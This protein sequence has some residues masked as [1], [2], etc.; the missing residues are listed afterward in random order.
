MVN[1]AHTSTFTRQD[2]VEMD[3]IFRLN[4]VNS[5][6]GFKPGNLIGTISE[7]GQ[8]NVAIVSS[9]L[10]LSSSPALIGFMQR[11]TT[12]PRHT[13]QNIKETGVFTINHIHSGM[14]D[15]AHYTSAKFPREESEFDA[16]GL[17]ASF[18]DG[19]KAPFVDESQIQM[20]MSYVEEYHIKSSD[21][22]LMVGQIE[23]IFLPER[24][25]RKDGSLQLD[26]A[27][28]IAITGLNNYHAAKQ[29]ASYPYARPGQFP[30]KQQ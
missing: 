27:T 1:K 6:T 12:V 23:M 13:Y 26:E 9:V 28:T 30:E 25:V 19:F 4:L 20:G 18:I 14:T 29:I 10:H 17:T 3:R 5:I 7:S 15:K 21:T 11:P 8:N 24:I 2:L 22:I 16:C